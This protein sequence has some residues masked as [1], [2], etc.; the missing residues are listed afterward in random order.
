MAF[1]GKGD[2]MKRFGNLT[3]I[4]L[5][6]ALVV[7]PIGCGCQKKITSKVTEKAIEKAIES[8]AKKDGKDVD[9][10]LDSDKGAVSITSKDGSETVKMSSD[11][12]SVSV[13]TGDG[14]FS[15]GDSAKLPDN[16]PKDVPLYSNAKLEFVSTQ[17]KDEM[18]SINFTSQ[19]P[20]EKVA[21]FFKKELAA[22]GWT[23]EQNINQAGDQPMQ[24]MTSQKG[25]RS[26]MVTISRESDKTSIAV[27]SGKGM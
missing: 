10:K 12:N 9:V 26:I 23:E 5:L 17:A 6:A 7:L 25:D 3:A 22:K 2:E 21:D 19:D 27:I 16:F 4:A 14:A 18:F 8:N 11:K 20:I 15:S 24:M 1:T 13:Q